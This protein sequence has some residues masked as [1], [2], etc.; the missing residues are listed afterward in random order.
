MFIFLFF[1]TIRTENNQCRNNDCNTDFEY[2]MNENF[3][4]Y[5]NC[6]YRLR[7]KG[8]FIADQVRQS[9]ITLKNCAE[10]CRR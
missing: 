6:R 5:Q 9:S 4:Y 7:N 8:L 2:G 1:S 3:E 10:T